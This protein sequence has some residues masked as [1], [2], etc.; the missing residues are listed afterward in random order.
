MATVQQAVEVGVSTSGTVGKSR[1]LDFRVFVGVSEYPVF[2]KRPRINFGDVMADQSAEQRRVV[3]ASAC[4]YDPTVGG[5]EQSGVPAY[6]APSLPRPAGES[7]SFGQ[8]G[9]SVDVDDMCTASGGTTKVRRQLARDRGSR[10]RRQQPGTVRA[11][12]ELDDAT[13]VPVTDPIVH[14]A[15][16][17]EGL[18]RESPT[19]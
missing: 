18:Q 6:R 16:L 13:D 10:T 14:A 8:Q 11:A 17:I 7:S 5:R 2:D 4:H 1:G 3:G 19:T 12:G 9:A 15:S